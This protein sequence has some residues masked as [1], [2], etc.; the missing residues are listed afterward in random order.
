LVGSPITLWNSGTEINPI[1]TPTDPCPTGYRVPTTT[2]LIA[3]YNAFSTQDLAGAYASNLKLTKVGGIRDGTATGTGIIL[4]FPSFYLWSSKY[5]IALD[6]R[7]MTNGVNNTINF[8]PSYG[9][10]VRCIKEE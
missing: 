7:V 6:L 8:F 2:E 5:K 4:N 1:K 3:E 9:A 10:T